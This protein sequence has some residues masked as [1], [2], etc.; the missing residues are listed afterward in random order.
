MRAIDR[1]IRVSA[2]IATLTVVSCA[3]P[4]SSKATDSATDTAAA[5]AQLVQLEAEARAL[6]T[7]GGCSA[8]NLCRTAPVGAKGCGGPRQYLVYCS[9]TTDSVALFR[10]LDALKAAEIKFNQSVNAISTCEFRLPPA[11]VSEGGSCRADP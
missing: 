1:G 11:V 3:A 4:G 10:K 2:W 5:R 9:A 6:V 7:P 8:A